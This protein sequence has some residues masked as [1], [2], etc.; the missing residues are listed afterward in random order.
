MCSSDLERL[1]EALKKEDGAEIKSATDDLNQAWHSVSEEMY[2]Q[3]T[4]ASADPQGAP[5]ADA[6][7][8]TPSPGTE[9]GSAPEGEVIDAEFEVEDEEKK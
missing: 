6:G 5:G 4:A 9:A 3:A 7:P 8:Q 1:K 2:K